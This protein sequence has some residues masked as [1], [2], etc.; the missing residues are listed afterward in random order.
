MGQLKAALE[1]LVNPLRQSYHP[2]RAA[3]YQGQ[4]HSL[5]IDDGRLKAA[6]ARPGA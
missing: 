2:L 1:H 6:R 3:E 5:V 4:D